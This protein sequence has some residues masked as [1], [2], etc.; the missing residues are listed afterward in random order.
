MSSQSDKKL[1]FEGAIFS[2]YQWQ[3]L[4]Y[5]G[6]YATFEQLDRSD[7]ACIVAITPDNQFII[8]Q[9]EQPHVGSFTSLAGGVVD[10]GEEPAAAARR[11]LLE[12]TGYVS[13]DW[14]QWFTYQPSKKIN[15]QIHV[16]I[17]R[18]CIQVAEQNLD[19]GEKIA[20]ELVS[21]DELLATMLQDEFR[22]R[23]VSWKV[24]Q[25]WITEGKAAVEQLLVGVS[26]E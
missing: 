12:E 21:F 6:S 15:W 10:P 7:T 23:E 13:L 1:I 3:Q 5:D 20:V 11:E 16:Y 19:G 9:Q 22:D 2:V 26:D 17:A 25:L 4:L 8:T 24:M 18:N 14:E